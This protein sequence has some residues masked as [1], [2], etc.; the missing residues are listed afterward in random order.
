MNDRFYCEKIPL[1]YISEINRFEIKDKNKFCIIFNDSL[2]DTTLFVY[3]SMCDDEWDMNRA[4][5]NMQWFAS[6]YL[7]DKPRWDVSRGRG[8][9]IYDIRFNNKKYKYNIINWLPNLYQ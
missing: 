5:K 9:G 1:M 2:Y 6:V 7:K 4:I 3:H 8:S